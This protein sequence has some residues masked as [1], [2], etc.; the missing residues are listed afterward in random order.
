MPRMPP[1]C[2]LEQIAQSLRINARH[3]NMRPNPVDNQCPQQEPQP[4]L[5]I[6]ELSTL[7]DRARTSCQKTITSACSLFCNAAAGGFD[8]RPRTLVAPTP[9][10]MTLRL[11]SPE[12][13]TFADNACCETRLACISVEQIDLVNRQRVD[14]RQADFD[15]C[16]PWSEK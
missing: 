7:A 1:C 3:R 16:A 10:S 14:F 6:A 4:A 11:I 15:S 13:T 8:R 9:L 12:S 2:L 5:E